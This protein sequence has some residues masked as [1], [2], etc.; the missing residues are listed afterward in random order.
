MIYGNT[1][2]P[3]TTRKAGFFLL[4]YL[5]SIPTEMQKML[6]RLCNFNYAKM[7]CNFDHLYFEWVVPHPAICLEVEVGRSCCWSTNFAAILMSNHS[8]QIISILRLGRDGKMAY[9]FSLS[10]RLIYNYK[11]KK[12]IVILA[13][14]SRERSIFYF[15]SSIFL[16]TFDQHILYCR[17]F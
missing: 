13:V 9:C 17:Q 15:T 1:T 11:L 8:N 5:Q 3:S 12:K 7:C 10:R 14:V 2:P 4:E 16:I 6:E